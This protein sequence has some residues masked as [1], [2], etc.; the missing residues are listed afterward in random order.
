[1]SLLASTRVATI[2]GDAQVPW[3]DAIETRLGATSGALGALKGIRMTGMSGFVSS[4]L[5]GLR[6]DEIKSSF[7]YRVW[8]VLLNAGCE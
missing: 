5:T 4:M 6:K 8:N 3:L 7:R 1:M 2:A